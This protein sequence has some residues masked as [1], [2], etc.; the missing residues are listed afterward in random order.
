[1]KVFFDTI[2]CRLNQA[3]IERYAAQFTALGHEIVPDA[4]SAD[5]AVVN[6]CSVTA[7]AASD[8]RGKVRSAARGGAQVVVTGC[9]SSMEPQ[10]AAAMEGVTQVIPNGEK[11]DLTAAVLGLEKAGF[12]TEPLKRVTLPGVHARTRAFIKV[13]DGCDNHCTFCVTHLVRG[14]ARSVG[15]ARVLHD[16]QSAVSAGGK[17]IVLTG[18]NLGAWGLDLEPGEELADLIEFLLKAH[19]KSAVLN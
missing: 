1:M 3:E 19:H 12:D 15:K 14:K 11:D 2:G 7:A 8:S 5:I 18:V 10:E 9:W 13:Q 16:V 4:A 17:E 6:T